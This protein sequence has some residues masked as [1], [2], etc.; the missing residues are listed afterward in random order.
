MVHRKKS[1]GPGGSSVAHAMPPVPKN[2]YNA[3]LVERDRQ[4]KA[5]RAEKQQEEAAK[6]ARKFKLYPKELLLELRRLYDFEGYTSEQVMLKAQEFGFWWSKQDVYSRVVQRLTH[7]NVLP[8]KGHEP[9]WP[10]R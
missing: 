2:V 8:Q 5:K 10:K 7:R 1:D 6:D 3:M 9:Y 4:Y